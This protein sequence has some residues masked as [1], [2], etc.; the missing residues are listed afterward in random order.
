VKYQAK[1]VQSG[2]TQHEQKNKKTVE[3]STAEAL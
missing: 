3:G 1:M 2:V